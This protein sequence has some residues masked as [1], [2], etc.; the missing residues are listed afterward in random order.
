MGGHD[1]TGRPETLTSP[2]IAA[3]GSNKLGWQ[4]GV[5]GDRVTH[6]RFLDFPPVPLGMARL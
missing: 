2:G 5:P 6:A 4:Q 1:F 3:R